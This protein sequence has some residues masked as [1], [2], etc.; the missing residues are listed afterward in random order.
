MEVE[1]KRERWGRKQ[2]EI[3]EQ[4]DTLVKEGKKNSTSTFLVQR[5]KQ[6]FVPLRRRSP[7][8]SSHSARSLAAM[9]RYV[10]LTRARS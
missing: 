10:F 7:S 1:E 4:R 9:E 5:E 2:E 8:A 3:G 6:A